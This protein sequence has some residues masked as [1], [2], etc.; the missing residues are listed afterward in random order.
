MLTEDHFG[1]VEAHLLF[2]EDAVL[3]E[4]VVQVAAVHQVQN[5]AQLV[6]SVEGVRHAHYKGTVLLSA[7][8]KRYQ[9]QYTYAQYDF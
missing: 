1:G 9:L 3:R 4:V 8:K 6:G 7:H 2:V 5:E